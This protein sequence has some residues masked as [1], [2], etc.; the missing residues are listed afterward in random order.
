MLS[1]PVGFHHQ[2]TDPG[3]PQI[4]KYLHMILTMGVAELVHSR[5]VP[6]RV[7]I[8]EAL[9]LTR[10]YCDEDAVAF[11]NGVL[12]AAAAKVYPD[13][14]PAVGPAPEDEEPD[15]DDGDDELDDFG[16]DKELR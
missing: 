8:N 7:V 4:W 15:Q 9:E 2:Y 1:T 16:P 12:D 10:R 6:V 3:I 5:D 14:I 11:V 13:G